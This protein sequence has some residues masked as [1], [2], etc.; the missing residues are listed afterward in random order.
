MPEKLVG[1]VTHYYKRI[2]V[3]IVEVTGRLKLGDTIHVK[4]G[5]TDF[6]QT[7]DSMEIEHEPIEVAQAGQVIGLKIAGKVRDNDGVYLV[8][9]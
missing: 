8:E 4:G 2:G 5:T 6:E 7:V 1:R 9:E 3:A